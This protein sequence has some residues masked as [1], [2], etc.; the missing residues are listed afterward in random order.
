MVR[1]IEYRQLVTILALFLIVQLS[2][3]LIAFWLATPTQV[4]QSGT[5]QSGTPDVMFY[6]AYMIVTAALLMLLFRV[7]RGNALFV[8][9][10]AIVVVSATFYLFVIVLGSLLPQ[11]GG[12]YAIAISLVMAIALIVAKNRWPQ[13]R[14]LTAVWPA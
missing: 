5:P 9:I 7:Y 3:V 10:E 2:G 4:I 8:V 14:N 6:F 1:S 12:A 11:A 13:L